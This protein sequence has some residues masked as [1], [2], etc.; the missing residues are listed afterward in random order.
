M[1]HDEVVTDRVENVGVVAARIGR[2]ESLIQFQVEDQVPQAER[3]QAV[4]VRRRQAHTVRTVDFDEPA[5]IHVVIVIGSNE[6]RRKSRSSQASRAHSA[7][8]RQFFPSGAPTILLGMPTATSP[9]SYS[10]CDAWWR[11][12]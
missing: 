5:G 9:G 2:I 6:W 8:P 3:C 12:K 10:P 1:F 7:P 4:C 11:E